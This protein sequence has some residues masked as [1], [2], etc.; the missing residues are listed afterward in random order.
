MSRLPVIL[1][2]SATL[3]A[4]GALFTLTACD[5]TTCDGA[6][7]QIY[8]EEGCQLTPINPSTSSREDALDNCIDACGTALYK[9]T[10]PNDDSGGAGSDVQSLDNEADAIDFI[11]CVQGQD[12][13]SANFNQTCR[14]LDFSC[15]RILW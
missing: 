1:R 7:Q 14:D 4:V 6:C 8:G 13:S 5:D 3:L 15:P 9:T 10:D 12:Y 11:Q 2:F